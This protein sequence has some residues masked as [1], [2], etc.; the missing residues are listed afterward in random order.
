MG[1]SK[2]HKF[3][4]I[5]NEIEKDEDETTPPFIAVQLGKERQ[6]TYAF[7]DSGADGNTILYEL[8]RKLED[9]KLIEIDVV[10][11][12][13]TG[14]TTKAFGMCKLDLNVSELICRDKF[15]VTLPEM[16]DVLTI[17]ERTWQRKYNCFLNW[18][19]KDELIAR[20]WTTNYGFHC[21]NW[22]RAM[23]IL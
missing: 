18:S 6:Q 23:L 15:F 17:L 5:T 9:V 10:F 1:L 13:Y 22:M 4:I 7:I 3:N 19:C 21:D 16:Q 14:H 8:F 12:T 11:Q 20:V 2:H